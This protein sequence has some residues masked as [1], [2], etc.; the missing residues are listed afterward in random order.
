MC[1]LTMFKSYRLEIRRC[2]GWVVRSERERERERERIGENWR[3]LE[4]GVGQCIHRNDSRLYRERE[5]EKE[6]ERERE[7]EREKEGGVVVI[8]II[9][10]NENI[11]INSSDY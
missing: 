4:R 7:R 10:S 9:D 11:F 3:E 2:E 5:R 1:L 6:R 8:Y